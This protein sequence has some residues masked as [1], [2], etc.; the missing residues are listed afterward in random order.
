MLDQLIPALI[1]IFFIFLFFFGTLLNF[2]GYNK[3]IE[4]IQKIES[5]DI[6]KIIQGRLK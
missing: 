5:R 3:R 1:F 2:N 4:L 6:K